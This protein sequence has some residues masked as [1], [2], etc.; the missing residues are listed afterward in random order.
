MHTRQAFFGRDRVAVAER[1]DA[2]S[3][4]AAR[5]AGSS[6]PPGTVT[7]A[8]SIA[9]RDI[10]HRWNTPS[11]TIGA[12]DRVGGGLAE[13]ADAG[14]AHRLADL[15][16]QR[17]VALRR[18]VGEA[19]DRFLLPHGADPARHALAARLVAEERRDLLQLVDHVD[20]L[21]VHHHHARTRA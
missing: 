17:Q 1:R 7:S 16:Q 3:A 11:R 20:V 19:F 8:P 21:V 18:R 10:A 15:A 2:A 6:C 12:V 5:L 14:V 9:E 4:T 13:A